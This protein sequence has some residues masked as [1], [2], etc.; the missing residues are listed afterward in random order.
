MRFFARLVLAA[1]TLFWFAALSARAGQPPTDSVYRLDVPLVD[2]DGKGQHLADRRGRPL[3]VG[4]FYTS[5]HNVCPLIVDTMLATER[6]LAS[7]GGNG[8]DVLL[9]S[10]D[11]SR[12]DPIAL[13][14]TAD[15][16]KLDTRRWTLARTEPAD[17]R[18]LAAVLGIQYR[19][20]D[21]GEFN[22]SSALILLDGEGRIA[23]RTERIGTT[24]PAFVE[25]ITKALAA[26][27]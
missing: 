6:A 25:A 12:D 5:C 7:D 1:A 24:D 3:V 26:T 27:K 2:Q 23:A 15:S 21:D 4:M 10:F 17:V 20:L 13:K 19:A 22:H 8:V 11:A 14:R 16:R 9:V 18:K